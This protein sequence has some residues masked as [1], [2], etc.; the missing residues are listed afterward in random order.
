MR[1]AAA[2]DAVRHEMATLRQL[3]SHPRIVSCVG[4]LEESERALLFLELA[5][6]GD[7]ETCGERLLIAWM[8]LMDS[9]AEL[10]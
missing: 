6:G 8:P 5:P 10:R 3:G 2:Y 1:S 9:F 7:L 4:W